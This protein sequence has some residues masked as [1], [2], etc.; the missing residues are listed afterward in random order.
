MVSSQQ[1]ARGWNAADICTNCV[2]TI[3]STRDRNMVPTA[4]SVNALDFERAVEGSILT[5]NKRLSLK[6]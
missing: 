5:A 3:P 6:I 2:S 4:Q 1:S